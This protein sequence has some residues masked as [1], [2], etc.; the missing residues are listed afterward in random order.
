MHQAVPLD[1]IKSFVE[2]KLKNNTRCI[3]AIATVK[4]VGDIGKTLSEATTKDKTRLVPA[5][6]GRDE[7]LEPIS[8]N[9]RN[10]FDS[11]ILQSNWSEV[12]RPASIIFFRK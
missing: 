3:S 10:A 9:F 5:H 7:W 2:M 4:Q 1:S 6:Q 12:S 8:E 11:S